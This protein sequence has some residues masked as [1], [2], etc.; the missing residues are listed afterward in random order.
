MSTG[1]YTTADEEGQSGGNESDGPGG[2]AVDGP[3]DSPTTRFERVSPARGVLPTRDDVA[4]Q[5]DTL[6]D[7]DETM[8]ELR[9]RA[10]RRVG[11][12]LVGRYELLNVLGTGGAGAVYSALDQKTGE[13]VAVKLLHERLSASSEHIARFE[14]EARAAAAIGHSS[15]VK[16]LDVSRDETNALFM[17]LE[18]LEG[19]AL[20]Y[21]I[22]EERLSV[23]DIVEIGRQLLGALGAAHARGIIHRDVKPEN[24]F[25]TY[26]PSGALRVKLLD[27]GIAKMLRRDVATTFSTMD[28]L[29]VGTPHYMSPQMCAGEPANEGADLW[30]AGA[31]L[32]HCFAGRP[33]FD[34]GHVGRLLMRIV[35]DPAPSLGSFRKDLPPQVVIAIDRALHKDPESRWPTAR[36]FA[37]ALSMGGAPV[38]NLDW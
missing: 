14:R 1:T 3:M 15:V 5:H 7:L 17:V 20:F 4:L 21:A 35:R 2:D 8:R 13:R 18:L 36:A 16:V 28:G 19:E 34:D 6:Q 37:D 24:I 23:G 25:L 26:E 12:V 38:D 29:V 30:A 9:D 27:F 32:F 31:V 33:P 22:E 11:R 10:L